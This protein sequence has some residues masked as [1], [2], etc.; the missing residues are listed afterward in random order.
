MDLQL[1]SDEEIR[2][3]DQFLKAY[4][5]NSRI[6]RLSERVQKKYPDQEMPWEESLSRI[7]LFRVRQFI[8]SMENCDEKLFLYFYYVRGSSMEAC[9]E[10]LGISR[11]SVFRLKRRALSLASLSLRRDAEDAWDAGMRQRKPS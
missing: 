7:E 1:V 3:A 9:A 2:A 10:L 11:S 5:L 4:R 8:M 6:L